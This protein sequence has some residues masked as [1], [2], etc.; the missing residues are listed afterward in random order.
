MTDDEDLSV[1]EVVDWCGT[2]IT[3]WEVTRLRRLSQDWP[4]GD[5]R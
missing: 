5:S 3:V 2:G 1:R 4:N